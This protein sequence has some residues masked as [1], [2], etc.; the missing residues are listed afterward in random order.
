MDTKPPKMVSQQVGEFTIGHVS[1]EDI[2]NRTPTGETKYKPITDAL[3]ALAAG[4]ALTIS[5]PPKQDYKK[6]ASNMLNSVR[7]KL[8]ATRSRTTPKAIYLWLEVTKGKGA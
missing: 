3:V 7:Q 1:V 8:P 5:I 6:F 2:P 4:Q